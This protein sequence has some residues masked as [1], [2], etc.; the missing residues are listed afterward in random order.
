MDLPR[1]RSLAVFALL[2]AIS[3]SLQLAAADS[4]SS[5][6]FSSALDTL[7]KQI[8][9]DF[10]SLQLLRRAM[11]HPSFSEEN[12][13][14][15]SILGAST[16]QTFAALRY[17]QKDIDMTAKELSR[18]MAEIASVERSCAVD[19]MRLGLEKVVRVAPKSNVTASVVC[20]AFRAIFGAIALDSG[21]ADEAGSVFWSVHRGGEGFASEM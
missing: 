14:G 10:S 11:T 15:L 9:Y 1:R 5:S 2:F 13:K 16:V 3:V 20:G 21:R 18:K 12:N 4:S 17:L 19:G 6:P 8:G 7:Q